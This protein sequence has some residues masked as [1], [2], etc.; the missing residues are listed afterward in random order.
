[1]F[2]VFTIRPINKTKGFDQTNAICLLYYHSEY[3]HRICFKPSH[4]MHAG[5]V[6]IQETFTE[7]FM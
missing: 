6:N 4:L 5:T 2:I 1:M 3:T 7:R